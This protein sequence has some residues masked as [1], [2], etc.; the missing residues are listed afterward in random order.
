MGYVFIF[1][2]KHNTTWYII[3]KFYTFTQNRG[4][5]F[6]CYTFYVCCCCIYIF[7]IIMNIYIYIYFVYVYL[8]KHILTHFSWAVWTFCGL[9]FSMY[10]VKHLNSYIYIWIRMGIKAG[11]LK[12]VSVWQKCLCMVDKIECWIYIFPLFVPII[13]NPIFIF[14]TFFINAF[15]FYFR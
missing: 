5:F 11:Y 8:G 10:P 2:S 3:I 9:T 15:Q 4:M 6:L 14:L 13:S 1:W 12:C 7:C